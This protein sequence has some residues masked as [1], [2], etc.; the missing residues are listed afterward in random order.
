MR[1]LALKRIQKYDFR[2]LT[3]NK[4]K[5]IL[6]DREQFQLFKENY[7]IRD[8]RTVV[9]FNSKIIAAIDYQE[10]DM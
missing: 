7:K 9:W 1:I 8:S 5:V 6:F 10:D 3:P 2:G 4:I